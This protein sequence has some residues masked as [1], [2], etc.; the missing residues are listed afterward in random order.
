MPHLPELNSARFSLKPLDGGARRAGVLHQL[1]VEVE[2]VLPFRLIELRLPVLV[3]PAR[4]ERVGG[5][6]QERHVLAPAGLAAQADAVDAVAG[7]LARRV[8]DEVPGRRVRHGEAGLLEQVGAIHHHRALAIE[9]RGVEL[10]VGGQ[11]GADRRQ[12][13]VDVIVGAEIVE[14]DQPAL[15]GPDRHFIGAD[16][17]HVE[18]AALGGDVGRHLLAQRVLLQRDPLEADVRDSSR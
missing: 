7:D 15:L 18:L 8:G 11:A 14:R 5:R 12:Q 13:I 2:R 16:G 1:D 10:A 9:R 4:A 6:G 3:E 17:E